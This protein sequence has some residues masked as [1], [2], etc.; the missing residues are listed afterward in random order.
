MWRKLIVVN[1]LA[2]TAVN[3]GNSLIMS[4]MPRSFFRRSSKI[5]KAFSWERH[6]EVWHRLFKVKRWK[7]LLP[8]GSMII[9]SGHN[10]KSL[11]SYSDATLHIF[12]IEMRRAEL[13]HWMTMLYGILFCFWNPRWAA[14]LNILF[15]VVSNLP[16]IIVQRY[17][18]PRIEAIEMKRNIR[19]NACRNEDDPYE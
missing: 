18:R 10:K 7:D 13:T 19:M 2:W 5:F 3:I 4:R 16:F 12:L 8:D 1:A 6:G 17:N 9:K 14:L 15:G 11:P